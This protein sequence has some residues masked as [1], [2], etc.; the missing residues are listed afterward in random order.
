MSNKSCP[1]C[2][3]K[4][5]KRIRSRNIR[6]GI[7]IDYHCENCGRYFTIKGPYAR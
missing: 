3:S 7:R 5:V 4:K 1:E 6:F 2:G